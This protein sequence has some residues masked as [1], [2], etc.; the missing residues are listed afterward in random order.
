MF[1]DTF[2]AHTLY[3]RPHS[4]HRTFKGSKLLENYLHLSLTWEREEGPYG[5]LEARVLTE[6]PVV[7]YLSERWYRVW[8]VLTD[9]GWTVSD[10]FKFTC[11]FG[12]WCIMLSELFWV[13][14]DPDHKLRLQFYQSL[15]NYLSFQVYCQS[16]HWMSSFESLGNVTERLEKARYCIS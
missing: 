10:S 14:F 16:Y 8:E 4:S 1:N 11:I 3:T 7:L 12:F 15:C 6:D 13:L 2:D 9:S 5:E